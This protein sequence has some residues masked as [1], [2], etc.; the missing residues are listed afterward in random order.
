VKHLLHA[1]CDV[2]NG[3]K[4]PKLDRPALINLLA[5]A[6]RPA[7]LFSTHREPVDRFYSA[8]AEVARRGRLSRSISERAIELKDPLQTVKWMLEHQKEARI[9]QCNLHFAPAVTFLV[10]SS[11]SKST[12]PW[13]LDYIF[14]LHQPGELELLWRILINGS[15]YPYP[16]VDGRHHQDK[17]YQLCL[18]KVQSCKFASN[19]SRSLMPYVLM[20]AHE[21]TAWMNATLQQ[22]LYHLDEKCYQ[23]AQQAVKT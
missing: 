3:T 17:L 9:P 4:L 5:S 18:D 20:E 21:S 2:L 11:T 13:P 19:H 22:S 15:D 6:T 23:A 16:E 14:D 1:A 8:L 7:T 12:Q 10:K